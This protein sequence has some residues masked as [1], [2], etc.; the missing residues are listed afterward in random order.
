MELAG[1]EPPTSWVRFVQHGSAEKHL[2][3]PKETPKPWVTGRLSKDCSAREGTATI[4]GLR[5]SGADA[6]QA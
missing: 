3:Y 1:F 4:D 2:G 6:R 5:R